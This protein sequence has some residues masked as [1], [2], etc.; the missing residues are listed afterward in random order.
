[1]A[2]RRLVIRGSGGQGAVP[3]AAGSGPPAGTVRDPLFSPRT[4]GRHRRTPHLPAQGQRPCPPARRPHDGS[5]TA[6]VPEHHRRPAPPATA[7]EPRLASRP[8]P[9]IPRPRCA[10][11]SVPA[12]A[13]A[14]HPHPGH[15]RPPRSTTS[16]KHT[17]PARAGATTAAKHPRRRPAPA[18]PPQP[19]AHSRRPAAPARW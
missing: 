12:T 4:T 14:G 9:R 1:M 19:D 18:Q 6:A 17:A 5:H 3:S 10:A 15:L 16:A 2:S 7:P 8:G 13:P 11:P